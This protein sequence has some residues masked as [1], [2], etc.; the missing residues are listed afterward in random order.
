MS[1]ESRESR[2]V[3]PRWPVSCRA[4]SLEQRRH[5][6]NNAPGA[7]VARSNAIARSPK[8]FYEPRLVI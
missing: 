8:S 4:R 3:A 7:I 2:R 1:E 6:G 5:R